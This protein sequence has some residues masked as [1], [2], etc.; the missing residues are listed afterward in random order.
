[1][2]EYDYVMC[3]CCG[4]GHGRNVLKDPEPTWLHCDECAKLHGIKRSLP[5]TVNLH[6]NVT[7]AWV[8]IDKA[9]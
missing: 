2:K 6:P 8:R 3:P 9:T 5:G 1:M 7:W 4:I